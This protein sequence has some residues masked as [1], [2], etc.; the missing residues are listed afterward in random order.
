[1]TYPRNHQ[2]LFGEITLV[3]VVAIWGIS[4][5]F[6]K[7]ALQAVGP[8]AYNTI[9]MTLGAATL[10]VLIGRDW[11]RINRSYTWPALVTG[12]VLFLSYATQS[13][14][15]QFTT[16][17]KAGFLTG[18]SVIYVPLFS[19]L[20]L[21]RVPG[22]T[23]VAGVILAFIG[24]YLLSFAGGLGDLM[25]TPGDIWVAVSGVGWAFYIITLSNYSPRVDVMA[26]A[27]LHVLVSALLSGV[28][29]LLFEPLVVPVNSSAFWIGVISTGFFIIGLGTS[30]QTWVTRMISPTR[31]ALIAALEP[32]FAAGAAWWVGETITLR[33]ISG[34]VFIVAGMVVA[35]LRH[36]LKWGR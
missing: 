10:A 8:F 14:G 24:L 5:V 7:N 1:M 21:R 12:I 17:S 22:W 36:T 33:I 31:V 28:C 29:W 19:T 3:V 35:E 27:A 30:V 6:T 23:T 25:L 32:V 9:R 20:L 13:Y 26:Y 18:T 16:A 15:Q 11:R 34:G 4:F 2:T